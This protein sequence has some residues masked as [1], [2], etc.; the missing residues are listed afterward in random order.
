MEVEQQLV[1]IKKDN[2]KVQW[3]PRPPKTK[4]GYRTIPFGN[5]L[6]EILRRAKKDNLKIV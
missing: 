4:A 6:S 5:A 3:Q 2:G 1:G